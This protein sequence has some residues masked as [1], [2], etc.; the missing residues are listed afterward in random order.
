MTSFTNVKQW[1]QEIDKYAT[2][3]VNKLLVGNKCDL[4][5]KRAVDTQTA[6]DL[7]DSY[8]IPFLETSAKNSTNVE[9][10]FVRMASDIKKRYFP[11]L[12][13]SASI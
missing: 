7:A 4:T 2:E 5:S 11:P 3:N 1:L 9:E 6:K 12:F 8:G 13:L 10:A